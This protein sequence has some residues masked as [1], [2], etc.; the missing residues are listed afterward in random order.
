MSDENKIVTGKELLDDERIS[1]YLRGRMTA[2]EETAFMDELKIDDGLRSQAI[3]TAH[4][5]KAMKEIGEEN[6]EKV[7]EALTSISETAAKYFASRAWFF[8][9]NEVCYD[10]II[11]KDLK[12]EVRAKLKTE[13]P[14]TS[15]TVTTKRKRM[16]KLISIAACLFVLVG[17]G[18]K[19][20]NYRTVTKLGN[21]YCSVF[22][23]EQTPSRGIE[24]ADVAKELQTLYTNVQEGKDLDMTIKRLSI[25]WEVSKMK[26]Y[27]DYTN[28][29]AY[30]GWNLAI[31]Y[32]KDDDKESAIEVLEILASNADTTS[33]VMA[34][35]K[36]LLNKIN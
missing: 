26:T 29:A 34:K 13:S 24:N 18:F 6:D 22:V 28:E 20:Y 7:K 30:I 15:S 36:E 21:E 2:E 4:L 8:H 33:I 31:A 17:V 9:K 27:N 32:L 3:S 16:V 23:S 1:A 5:A 10:A 11:P 25:L 12:A 19:Y 14:S 35:A